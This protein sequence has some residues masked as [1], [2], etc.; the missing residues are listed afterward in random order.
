MGPDG[1]RLP[2]CFKYPNYPLIQLAWNRPLVLLG[3]DYG[4][5]T[6]GYYAVFGNEATG[7][8]G[9]F[10]KV[11]AD[12]WSLYLQDSWTI[13]DR[14]TL[15]LG[16][17]TES[18]Y[19]PP[20]TADPAF[21]G[22]K[23]VNFPFG[24]KLAPRLGFIYD[25]NGDASLKIFGSYGLYY[26][27]MKLYS[28]AMTF[29][30]FSNSAIFYKLDTYEWD[31]LGLNSNY[32]GDV[33]TTFNFLPLS[34]DTIDPDLRPMSQ[35]EITFGI[36]RKLAENLSVT[37]R[38]VQKH[39]RYA[40]EDVGVVS[41]GSVA[42]YMTNPGYGYSRTTADGGKF[43]PRYPPVPRAKREYWALNLSLE[44]RFAGSW[45]GGFSYT[46]S[47]LTGNYSGLASSDEYQ[48]T[49]EGRNSPNVE[50]FFDAWYLAYD[51][52]LNPIDGP[53]GTDRTHVFKL[54]GAYTF[55]FRL[56]V[57]ALMNAM[58]GRPMT[59]YWNITSDNYMP[60][61]RGNLGRTPFLWI[62]NVYA[63]YALRLGR[64]T[65]AFNVNVDNVFNIATATAVYPYR[66]LFNLTVTEDTILAGDW[67]LDDSVGYVPNN[68]FGKVGLFYPP[69]SARLGMRY[70]F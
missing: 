52:S 65:L 15:N 53:L 27:V 25:F 30:G 26:D 35:R 55:P 66:N 60:Y 29:G 46:W 34:F 12:R 67:Q 32:P 47:R 42:Y 38:L 10:Y 39:L 69:I 41:D 63:E 45:M 24:E 43:D 56:T 14:L 70:S 68:A 36:E 48:P 58:S 9:L 5:G 11:R 13:K 20:Y 62:F 23:S 2:G 57:G 44:K 18:E 64:T 59:E 1:G 16:I 3:Q 6:Y 50:L 31:T 22:M 33:L 19:I 7:P 28:A 51:R 49:G 54:Y 37:A 40:I 61:N 4:Q 8:R 17:R 21:A